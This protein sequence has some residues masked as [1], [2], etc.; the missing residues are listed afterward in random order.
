MKE[1]ILNLIN[2][3]GYLSI[4]FLIAI[5]NIFPPIPSEVI[6]CFSGFISKSAHLKLSLVI[7]SATLGS[8][9]GAIILYYLGYILNKERIMNIA[10]GKIGTILRL[11]KDKIIDSLVCFE[12]KGS[13]TIFFCRFIPIIRSL[14]SIPAGIAHYDIKKFLVYTTIGSLM[15]NTILILL[16]NIMGENWNIITNFFDK[17][18][19]L[20]VF[21]ILITYYLHKKVKNKTSI[22]VINSNEL[23]S[24]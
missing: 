2:K 19:L 18:S 21:V 13:K 11:K 12:E 10:D 20:I 7:L 22:K 6:L 16:G 14:I 24:K 9:I 1:I 8:L 17:Y 15:W 3:Y 23:N 4:I 5:E